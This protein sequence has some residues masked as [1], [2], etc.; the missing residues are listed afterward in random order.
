MNLG[1]EINQIAEQ[2]TA[3]RLEVSLREVTDTVKW[4]QRGIEDIRTMLRDIMTRQL[5]TMTLL[6]QQSNNIRL[7]MKI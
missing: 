4:N 6:A 2:G 1:E 5:L 7:L 3:E